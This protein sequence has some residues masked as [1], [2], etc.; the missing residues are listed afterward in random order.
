MLLTWGAQCH[1]NVHSIFKTKDVGRRS[2]ASQLGLTTAAKVLYEI[3]STSITGKLNTEQNTLLMEF[4]VPRSL[5]SSDA[6]F[7]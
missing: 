4:H 3:K 2:N 6:T 1:L 7:G 5:E